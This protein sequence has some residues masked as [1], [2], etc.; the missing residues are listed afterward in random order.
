MIFIRNKNLF[1]EKDKN[2][3]INIL[4][5]KT[6]LLKGKKN[7]CTI[8]DS[9]E[10]IEEAME[11]WS[12]GFLSTF[13]YLMILNT[14]SGRTYNNLAQYPIFPW[15]LKDYSSKEIDLNESSTYRDLSYPIYAQ[16]EEVRENLKIKY[17][18]FEENEIKYHCGSHYSNSGFVCYYLI[19]VKPFSNIAA[20]IQGNCFDTPDRLFFNIQKFYIV[21]EKY[22]EL[23]P[24]IFNLPELYIN[25]NNYVYGKTT[26]NIQVLDVVLPPWALHSP[27]LFSKMNKKALE[28]QFVSQHIN[29]WI[30]LIF[31]YKR[32]GSEAEKSYNVLKDIFANFDPKKDVKWV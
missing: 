2:K 8:T 23:I 14:L 3:L 28:S 1:I 29:D 21:Q 18:S 24:D 13:S 16:E 15:I 20:E 27:R 7:S 12:E 11:K 22:Q 9:K 32:S 26:D 10:I 31:G 5:H 25:I 17:E 19:R 30:D 4:K 6:K